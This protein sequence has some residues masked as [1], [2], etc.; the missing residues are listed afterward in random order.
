MNSE[1]HNK[2]YMCMGMFLKEDD[3]IWTVSDRIVGMWS[4]WLHSL[5]WKDGQG[6]WPGCRLAQKVVSKESTNA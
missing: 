2:G 3:G 5:V 6:K 1:L 4:A